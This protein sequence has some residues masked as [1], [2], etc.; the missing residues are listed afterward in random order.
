MIHRRSLVGGAL[1]MLAGPGLIGRAG[2]AD[3]HITLVVGGPAGS[4]VDQ[5]AR[6][7]TPF[8]ERHL[9]GARVAIA[10]RPGEVGLVALRM[11][12]D[13][14]PDGGTLGWVSTPALPAR[15][16]DHRGAERL[17]DSLTLVGAVAKEPIAIVSAAD[18]PV[19]S[20]RELIARSSE[21]AGAIPLGTP[22]TGS[23]PHLAALKF[24]ALAGTKLNI[25]AFPSAAAARQAALAGHVAAALLALGDAIDFLRAGKLVGLGIAARR[26]A[27]AFPDLTP[28]QDAGLPLSAVIHRGIALPTGC[29]ADTVARLCTALQSVV[30]DPD[31]TAL[32]TQSGFRP[33]WVPGN[34]WTTQTATDREALAR[35]WRDESWLAVGFG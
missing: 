32:G 30:T 1:G 27:D 4:S 5:G 20:A 28:L 15:S 9:P 23:A 8:L 2:A 7:F 21:D 11:V 35:L 18:G 14:A 31:F 13:A 25:V 12:A 3:L 6:A 16:V 34:A 26:R 17:L 24:Q 33:I 10:N 19:T 29:P 22:P